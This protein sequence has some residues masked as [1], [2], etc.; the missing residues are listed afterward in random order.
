MSLRG[1]T[2][3]PVHLQAVGCLPILHFL[4][5]DLSLPRKACRVK[6]DLVLLDT[7][8]QNHMFLL[9]KEVLL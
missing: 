1:A 9:L 8:T 4:S 6:T 5:P 7:L 2:E 3:V